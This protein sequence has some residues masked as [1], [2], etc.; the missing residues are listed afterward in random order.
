MESALTR[1]EQDYKVA[2]GKWR[3][4]VWLKID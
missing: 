3:R 1:R 2:E 4:E